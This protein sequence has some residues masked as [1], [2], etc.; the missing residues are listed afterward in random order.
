MN[1]RVQLLRYGIVGM[2]SNVALYV[3]YLLL[4]LLGMGP[5]LAMTVTYAMGVAQTFIFNRRW[6]FASGESGPSALIRYVLVYALGYAVNMVLLWWLVGQ[7]KW[8]HQLV[9]AGAILL[10]AMMIFVLQREWVFR[11]GSTTR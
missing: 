3:V 11:R 4:T 5:A 8:P 7:W 9:Q 2:A 1:W 10:I 6:T